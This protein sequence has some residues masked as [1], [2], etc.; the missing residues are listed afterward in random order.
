MKTRILLRFV[1]VVAAVFMTGCM[2]MK[3]MGIKTE[4]F[5]RTPDGQAISLYT[6]TNRNGL[7]ARI[8]NYGGILVSLEVP[9][10]RG[11]LA[12]IT[13]GFGTLNGYLKEHPYFGA[14]VG[15]YAN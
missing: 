5:G 11:K 1:L 3:A 4:S 9:D 10:R 12:D 2:E 14:T 8:T 7:R 6:L 13:L 15:R